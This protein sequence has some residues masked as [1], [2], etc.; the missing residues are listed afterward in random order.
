M[1][2]RVGVRL[3][4]VVI[5]VSWIVYGVDLSIKSWG[6]LPVLGFLIRLSNRKHNSKLSNFQSKYFILEKNSAKMGAAVIT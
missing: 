2:L 3:V 1:K 5:V 4:D 6:V